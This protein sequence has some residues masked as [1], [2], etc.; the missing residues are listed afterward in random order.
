MGPLVS[1]LEGG[2]IH[3]QIFPT[4][5]CRKSLEGL[6]WPQRW[7]QKKLL[8]GIFTVCVR[9]LSEDTE[10]GTSWTFETMKSKSML[11]YNRLWDHDPQMWTYSH[12]KTHRFCSTRT[13][14][15]ILR[16]DVDVIGSERVAEAEHR[17]HGLGRLSVFHDIFC[18][19]WRFL[20]NVK[21]FFTIKHES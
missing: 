21:L 3:T 19:F 1:N 20:E 12:R 10:T 18:L 9:G 14:G 16:Y 8:P 7:Q 6:L 2:F 5:K 11:T 13:A 15:V 17:L 4:W